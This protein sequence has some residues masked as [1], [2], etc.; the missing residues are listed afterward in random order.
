MNYTIR[1]FVDKKE[2]FILPSIQREYVWEEEQI[3][4]L[5]DSLLR[6]FPIGHMLLW[7]LDGKDIK[8]KGIDFYKFLDN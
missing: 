7:K 6:S 4:R 5:F 8:D 3:C 2:Q 1:D